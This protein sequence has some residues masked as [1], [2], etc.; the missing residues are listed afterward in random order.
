MAFSFLANSHPPNA[1]K[2]FPIRHTY[3]LFERL[4]KNDANSLMLW[5]K[6]SVTTA[7]LP[8]HLGSLFLIALFAYLR[9][10]SN[11]EAQSLRW[12]MARPEFKTQT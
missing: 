3:V 5:P 6:V 10:K 4:E 8:I 12:R 11:N 2:P 1:Q 7:L 9:S